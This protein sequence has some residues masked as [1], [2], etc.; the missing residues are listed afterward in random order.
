MFCNFWYFFFFLMVIVMNLGSTGYISIEY[1][2]MTTLYLLA[3]VFM[4]WC[5]SA[6]YLKPKSR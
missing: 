3:I 6:I 4:R 5:Y 1:A 2:N